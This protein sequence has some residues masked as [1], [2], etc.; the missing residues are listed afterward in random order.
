MVEVKDL[1]KLWIKE[2][3]PSSGLLQSKR[4]LTVSKG[5]YFS[6]FNV[7]WLWK[8]L[9]L[10][11][12]ILFFPCSTFGD[13]QSKL[14]ILPVSLGNCRCIPEASFWAW[15]GDLRSLPEISRVGCTVCWTSRGLL[16]WIGWG[17]I[18]LLVFPTKHPLVSFTLNSQGEWGCTMVYYLPVLPLDSETVGEN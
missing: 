18:Y 13:L 8:L 15:A 1:I 6:W 11:F 10:R 17:A 7:P 4:A 12:G 3:C 9:P 5:G 16:F 2:G 14:Q